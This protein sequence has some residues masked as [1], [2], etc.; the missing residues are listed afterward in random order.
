MT[1]AKRSS[2]LPDVPTVAEQGYKGFDANT[3]YGLFMPANTP[4][5]IVATVNREVN[6]LL[7]TPELQ[8][9]IHDQGAEPSPMSPEQFE[10]QVRTEYPKWKDI[11][12][13]AG[14]TIE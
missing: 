11:V 12:H 9:A 14:V 7:A 6:K 5:D 2:A 3:W 10:N 4:R 13:N 1:T 8:A